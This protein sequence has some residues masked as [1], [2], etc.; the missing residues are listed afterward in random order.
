DRP[1]AELEAL[2]VDHW[3]R[4]KAERGPGEGL[5]IAEELRAHV[6]AVRPDWPTEADRA[7]DLAVHARLAAELRRVGPDAPAP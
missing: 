3:R 5:R 1:W 2:E 6:L 4:R 7:E